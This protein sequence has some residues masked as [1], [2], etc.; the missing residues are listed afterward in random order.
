MPT[1]WLKVQELRDQHDRLAD[2]GEWSDPDLEKGI[3]AAETRVLSGL[4]ARYTEAELPDDPDQTPPALKDLVGDLAV[5]L[6]YSRRFTTV[7]ESVGDI[8]ADARSSLQSI[9]RNQGALDLP[10]KPLE[11]QVRPEILT[12]P[13]RDDVLTLAS[14]EDW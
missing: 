6:L 4:L 13:D 11:D 10:A 14:L 1:R 2:A 12:T 3:L 8:G 7:E 5:W 9:V